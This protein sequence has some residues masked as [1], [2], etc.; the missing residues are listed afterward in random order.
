[1]TDSELRGVLDS[2]GLGPKRSGG[3]WLA[4]CP[5]HDDRTPSLSIR[6]LPDGKVLAHCFAGCRFRDIMSALSIRSSIGRSDR[7]VVDRKLPRR[8]VEAAWRQIESNPAARLVS[9]SERELGIPPGGLA[10]IGAVWSPDHDAIAAPMFDRP[11][12]TVMGVRLRNGSRGK[13]SIPGSHNALFVGPDRNGALFVPE[14]MTDSAA[15]AGLGYS[16]VGRPAARSGITDVVAITTGM[17][18]RR[19][20]VVGDRDSAGTSGAQETASALRSAGRNVS[21]L[22]P[23]IGTKDVRDWIAGGADRDEIDW[24]VRRIA[25]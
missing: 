24:F 19:I 20:I 11:G 14:G 8:S 16:V 5:C 6:V 9:V 25:T 15:L 17:N 3:Q 7:R 10:G 2:M 12:G 23:P 21:T 22:I 1:M 4:R 18:G 13:W